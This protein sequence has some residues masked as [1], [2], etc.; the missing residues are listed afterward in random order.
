MIDFRSDTVTQPTPAMR[1][2]MFKAPLG[3]DVYGEDPTVNELQRKAAALFGM[4]ASLFCPSGTM[5]NQIAIRLQAGPMQEVV[6][7]AGAHV[8]LYEGGGIAANAGASVRLIP[9][10]RGRITGA[11]VEAAVNAD[12]PHYPATRLVCLENT[13][14]RGGG[15]CYAWDEILAIRE[16]CARRGLGLHLD[17]ARLFNAL[18]A[19][20]QAPAEY[21]RVFDTISICLSKGLGAPVGSLLL[22]SAELVR[23]A[24]RFRKVMGGGMRQAG[25]LAAAG[26]HALDHHVGRL[27]EDH[28]RAR[29]LGQAIAA[30]SYV[31]T[32]LPV[33]TNI[34]LF[35]LK[36]GRTTETLTKH[37]SSRGIRAGGVG[38]EWGRFVL[39]LDI[40]DAGVERAI[41]ALREFGD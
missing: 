19:T 14:N 34:V 16:V 31:E 3:D 28:A 24:R 15:S 11:Q 21:G 4:E 27:S 22:G 2:A 5:T 39:H 13:S 36:P 32:L 38:A 12:D 10:D 6:C 33:E 23:E 8:Y 1:E 40:D 20:G 26:I 25:I 35:K 18:A 7:D 9:G 29:R 30:L 37:L 41:A 17:G